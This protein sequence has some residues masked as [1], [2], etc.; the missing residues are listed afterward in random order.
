[1]NLQIL[2]C[3]FNFKS[4]NPQIFKLVMVEWYKEWF[5]SPFYHKLYFERD[6]KEA[7][8]FI[9]KL[10]DY[11][12][13]PKDSRVLD[14]AC[15]KG[16]HSRFLAQQGLEV[17]GIDLSPDSIAF[18]KQFENSHLYFFQHDMRLPAWINYFDYAFN[19]FTSFGYFKTRREHDDAI[20]SIV[21][22]LKNS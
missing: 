12:K 7:Q 2:L 20:G 14:V 21:R 10:L 15:G 22:S 17:T 16:R 11:L 5:N 19:F 6:E 18:A 4:S 8:K 1:S 9:S 13:P 3:T